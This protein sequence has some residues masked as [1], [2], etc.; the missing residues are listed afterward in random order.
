MNDEAMQLGKTAWRFISDAVDY[1]GAPAVYSR[2]R[3]VAAEKGARDAI[4]RLVAMA[5][6]ATNYM[7]ERD[8]ARTQLD[9]FRKILSG[10]HSLINPPMVTH[11]GKAYEFQSPLIQ[12]QLQALSDRIRAIPDELDAIAPQE[13]QAA[14][15]PVAPKWIRPEDGVPESGTEVLVWSH[16]PWEKMPS[17]KLD[18]WAVQH[19]S[20]LSFSSATIPVGLGWDGHDF[21]EVVF[22]MHLPTPP[23]G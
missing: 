7:H 8:H 6:G 21:E 17:I 1:A 2:K 4:D 18:T 10:I 22:W 15:E 3:V 14:A 12:E 9:R 19:E 20:P 11:D 5:Q 13:P 16:R 23:K